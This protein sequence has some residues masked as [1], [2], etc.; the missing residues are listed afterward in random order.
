MPVIEFVPLPPEDRDFWLE[1][2]G[3]TREELEKK[4]IASMGIPAELLGG[5]RIGRTDDECQ[6]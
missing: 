3:A 6:G 2:F 4:I 1:A 5:N